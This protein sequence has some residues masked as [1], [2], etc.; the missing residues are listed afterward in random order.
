MAV[1][2]SK[3]ALF[4][5]KRPNPPPQIIED[6]DDIILVENFVPCFQEAKTCLSENGFGQKKGSA[7]SGVGTA[8]AFQVSSGCDI[9]CQDGDGQ[10]GQDGQDGDGQ[11]GQDGD[12]GCQHEAATDTGCHR[13]QAL[14]STLALGKM[15]RRPK[16]MS[17]RT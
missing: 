13:D 4:S 12:I 17:H 10:D 6:H 16:T 1:S 7:G 5:R 2:E 9:G 3:D 8:E 11:D 14:A 15:E